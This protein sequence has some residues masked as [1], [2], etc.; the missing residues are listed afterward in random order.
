MTHDEVLQYL[1]YD[2]CVLFGDVSTTTIEDSGWITCFYTEEDNINNKAEISYKLTDEGINFEGIFF[3]KFVP[4]DTSG[5]GMKTILVYQSTDARYMY[6]LILYL[7][8]IHQE[9]GVNTINGEEFKI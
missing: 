2:V 3:S 8:G 9:F 4:S 5:E 1:A 7:R 6:D